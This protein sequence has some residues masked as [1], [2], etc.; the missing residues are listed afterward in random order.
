MVSQF[1]IFKRCR[2]Y[3]DIPHTLAAAVAIVL[4]IPTSN[5]AEFGS[6]PSLQKGPLGNGLGFADFKDKSAEGLIGMRR[7]YG[8]EIVDDNSDTRV[9]QAAITSRLAAAGGLNFSKEFAAAAYA[10]V[11]F[12][13][14]DE[15]RTRLDPEAKLDAGYGTYE[16]GA[17]VTWQ[18]DHFIVGGGLGVMLY[19][20][21]DRTFTYG[22]D[23]YK[24]DASSAAMPVFKLHGGVNLG[25]LTTLLQ[26]RFFTRGE[27]SVEAK[28]PDDQKYIY[29]MQRKHPGEVA[30][31]SRY[32][33]S[34]EAAIGWRAAWVLTGQASD[35][36]D[37]FSI[38]YTS[39]GSTS[40]GGTKSRVTGG[41]I[42]NKNHL[43]IGAGGRFA[44]SGD[45]GVLGGLYYIQPYYADK[46]FASLEAGNL[47]GLEINLG[48][49]AEIGDIKGFVHAGYTL[50]SAVNFTQSD[51]SRS[52]IRINQSQKAPI[53]RD[54]KVRI[55]QGSWEVSA[56][57]SYQF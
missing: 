21:E 30:W 14:H 31:D 22:D 17:G 6:L 19:G 15:E 2:N 34:K 48:A 4:A 3:L 54:A 16:L 39:D 53:E 27:S 41:S 49:D 46:E 57:G 55:T 56:G 20:S 33:F 42:R 44:P 12:T 9:S 43:E 52:Q 32:Q 38:A 11:A 28:D 37:P 45:F 50:E 40:S 10:D 5:A 29:D 1:N 23:E 26:V 35:S 13:D 18:L 36:L 47:G 51:T 8:K 7:S 24:T 25:D